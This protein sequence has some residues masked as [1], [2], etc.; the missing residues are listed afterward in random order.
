M[1][2]VQSQKDPK[3]KKKREKE[4]GRKGGREEERGRKKKKKG[5][6]GGEREKRELGSEGKGEN[7]ANQ[8]Y[9]KVKN[10]RSKTSQ[11]SSQKT[12]FIISLFMQCP[13]KDRNHQK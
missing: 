3:K 13:R 7:P 12:N 5:G 10:S 8:A 4:K 9:E 6:G 1:L 2:Q 11:R